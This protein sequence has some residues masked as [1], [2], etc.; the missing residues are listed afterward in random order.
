MYY[1]KIDHIT[2]SNN[3]QPFT[4][5]QAWKQ[6]EGCGNAHIVS[7]NGRVVLA[8]AGRKTQRRI[9]VRN[10]YRKKDTTQ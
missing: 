6:I 3:G 7:S 9:D 1:L 8:H 2:Y 10:M 5:T 4:L